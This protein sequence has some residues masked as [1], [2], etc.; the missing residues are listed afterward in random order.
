MTRWELAPEV[1]LGL[2]KAAVTSDA[3]AKPAVRQRATA[4]HLL[5]RLERLPGQILADEVGEGKTFVALAVAA[6]VVLENPDTGPVVVMVP[7]GVADKWP[8]EWDT[9]HTQYLRPGHG[10][11]TCVA[12]NGL[13]LLR[14]LD[15]DPETAAQIVFLTHGA[16]HR[17]LNDPWVKLA[18]IRHAVLRHPYERTSVERYGRDVIKLKRSVPDAVVPELLATPLSGWR[19][20]LKRHG[21]DDLGDDPIPKPLVNAIS[22][23][24][25]ADRG[26]LLDALR[27][28]PQRNSDHFEERIRATRVSLNSAIGKLWRVWLANAEFRSPL[29]ILDE[30]HHTKNSDTQLAGLFQAGEEGTGALFGQFERL[31]FLTATPFQLGHYELIDVLGRFA[32]VAWDS[33]P[34]ERGEFQRHL[35]DL[36][37]RL[38]DAQEAAER[39]DEAWG[40]LTEHDVPTRDGWWSDANDD[41]SPR[42]AHVARS[43]RA[44]DSAM[45]D[46]EKLL[47]PWVSRSRK[48]DTLDDGRDRRVYLRGAQII[49]GGHDVG[50]DIDADGLLPFLLAGRAQVAFQRAR[51]RGELPARAR[52]LFADGL[53][54]SFEAYRD[55]RD[56]FGLDD[57][58]SDA[59]G[60][61]LDP[62]L[63]WYL[64]AISGALPDASGLTTHPKVARTVDRVLA[65]WKDGHKVVVFCHFRKTGTAL[66][67]QISLA[68]E[69]EIEVDAAA[70]WGCNTSQVW[71]RVKNL[72][73]RLERGPLAESMRHELEQIVRSGSVADETQQLQLV[74]ALMRFVRSPVT[75]ALYGPELLAGDD[76]RGMLA[77][78]RNG[79]P[80]RVRL[81]RVV[82]A[83][84]VC[85]SDQQKQ[86]FLDAAR[87]I[88]SRRYTATADGAED[89]D[90][91]A[92]APRDSLL[93]IVRL[94]NGA[95]HK[96]TRRRLL[97]A[98]NSPLMPDV[99]VAS[100]VL[101]EGVDLHL[102]CRHVIHHD[103]DWNPSTLEQ[104][105]GRVDRIGSLS[106]RTQEPVTI[107]LPYLAGTQDEKMYR[108]VRDRERWFQVVMGAK[109]ELDEQAL[110]DRAQ[111]VEFPEAAARNLAFDLRV[112]LAGQSSAP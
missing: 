45:R 24:P 44:A 54:S 14:V 15:D 72:G 94:A 98:F 36:G 10:I 96:D 33:V 25:R 75:L 105:T 87:S 95:V 78:R 88:Q 11:R 90:T 50:I 80:L 71:K 4:R 100:S 7:P 99:L 21:C 91:D 46:A 65:L 110:E 37:D 63:E 26:Q 89:R 51:R 111:R 67:R 22:T 58:A 106:D 48:K 112:R 77:G 16:F 53:A 32:G 103:L 3:F 30:A 18:L 38:G 102:E 83:F 93:P 85:V 56:G 42:A 12:E 47:R 69:R 62:E 92:A 28:M 64:D 52:S 66:R 19:T 27:V 17:Q 59:H 13:G 35:E 39:L 5:R 8:T 29:L 97:H 70:A 20:V 74:D 6:S 68:I 60:A 2:K 104:R 49:D 82:T 81:D 76:P 40:R 55:T 107:Y 23:I 31:L 109:H 43:Y 9:F 86:Q 84:E 101:A 34:L 41:D 57:D 73:K 108:V 79:V 61:T 1:T